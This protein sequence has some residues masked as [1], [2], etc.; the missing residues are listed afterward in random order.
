MLLV[1]KE[2]R[3]RADHDGNLAE[4]DVGEEALPDGLLPTLCIVNLNEGDIDIDKEGRGVGEIAQT[5]V[6]RHHRQN[7]AVVLEDG[8]LLELGVAKL[9]M[10][11]VFTIDRHDGADDHFLFATHQ[12]IRCRRG[13]SGSGGES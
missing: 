11:F 5:G 8:G 6:V 10:D 3:R 2:T 7:G 4:M 1:S 9:E 12:S 13:E